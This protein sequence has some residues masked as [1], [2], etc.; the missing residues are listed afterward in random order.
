MRRTANGNSQGG[1]IAVRIGDIGVRA[2]STL[3]ESLS[4]AKGVFGDLI[5]VYSA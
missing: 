5:E 2:Y 4:S 3:Q 1:Q